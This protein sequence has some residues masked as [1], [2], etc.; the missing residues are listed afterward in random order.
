VIDGGR[1]ACGSALLLAAVLTACSAPPSSPL[2]TSP[3]TFIDGR[4]GRVALVLDLDGA[5]RDPAEVDRLLE[6][7]TTDV[8]MISAPAG[9]GWRRAGAREPGRLRVAIV[10]ACA[11]GRTEACARESTRF[12]AAWRNGLLGPPTGAVIEDAIPGW[13]A[14]PAAIVIPTGQFTTGDTGGRETWFAGYAGRSVHLVRPIAVAR[15][16]TTVA[17]FRR[18]VDA[19]GYR[20]GRGCQ[21]HTRDQIW[22]THAVASWLNPVIPQ[23]AD[24]PVTCVTFEDA[25]AYAA[26][27]TAV[28]GHTW[29]LPTEAEAE[30]FVRSGHTGRFGVDAATIA[31][32][33]SR[34]N[35]ADQASG[36]AYANACDDGFAATAPVGSFPPNAFGLFDATGNV[37][38][39]TSDCMRGEVVRVIR[40][41]VGLAPSDAST[42]GNSDCHGRHVVRGGA[43]LS[44]PGNLEVAHRE[45]EALRSN[46][47][48]FR[49]VRELP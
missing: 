48:G 21:H 11:G 10:E 31:D 2:P 25:D 5:D 24:H 35:G 13:P 30:F 29:R 18:F 28:T 47:A 22:E 44:S 20:P 32:L 9:A 40:D 33:C 14:A 12:I 1:A 34:A 37:W 8:G 17:Q 4:H 49:L 38:E 7:G 23:R 16:E 15:T 41:T 19:S 46:R 3:V 36:L 6:G 45:I 27:M 42:S 39:L 43:F 26:W